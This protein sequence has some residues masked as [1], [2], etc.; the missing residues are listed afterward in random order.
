MQHNNQ[1]TLLMNFGDGHSTLIINYASDI[2]I[3]IYTYMHIYI[4]IDL[5]RFIIYIAYTI[6]MCKLMA[7]IH[8]HSV[9]HRKYI[10]MHMYCKHTCTYMYIYAYTDTY[11]YIY[12]LLLDNSKRQPYIP[13]K[14]RSCDC[15]TDQSNDL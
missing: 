6:Y 9:Y 12:N 3:H 10:Y 1:A 13:I 4:Y 8:I 11:M 7:Y 14:C 5:D 2:H 15:E